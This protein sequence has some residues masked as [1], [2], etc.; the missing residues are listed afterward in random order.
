MPRK[1]ISCSMLWLRPDRAEPMRKTRDPEHQ[2]WL[3]AEQVGQLAVERHGDRGRQ[4]VD[5]D[6]P[7]VQLVAVQIGDDL[8]QR[9]ADD[10]LV[11]G[12]EEQSE[13]NGAEDLELLPMAQA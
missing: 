12:A 5:R 2:E 8:G 11:E 6:D 13:Q 10:G 3:A 7:R 9:G 1:M 4:Q